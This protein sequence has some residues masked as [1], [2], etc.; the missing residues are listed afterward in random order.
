ML[1][2]DFVDIVEGG[3][4]FF[5]EIIDGLVLALLKAL[6]ITRE[7]DGTQVS[8]LAYAALYVLCIL[9]AIYLCL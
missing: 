9:V 2:P 3:F 1:L 6:E 8:F 5:Q 7:W 4:L